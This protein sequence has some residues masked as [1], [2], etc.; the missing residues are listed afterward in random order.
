MKKIVPFCIVI[1]LMS[2]PGCY[3]MRLATKAQ[4]A[5]ELQRKHANIYLWG[6]VQKPQYLATPLCDTLGVNG[7]SEVYVRTNF[8]YALLTV[9]TLGIWCPITIEY[10]CSKPCQPSGDDPL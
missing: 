5:T 10:R 4:P 7:V 8:G 2:A 1:T 9:A 3:N 6:L